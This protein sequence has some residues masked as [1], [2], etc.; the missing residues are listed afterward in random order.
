MPILNVK[1]SQ[2]PAL[3]PAVIGKVAATLS[4]LTHAI[5]GKD[6]ALTA[7]AIDLV[8]ASQWF[9]G[10]TSLADAQQS[11][12]WLDIVVTESTN[13]KDEKAAYVR[14]VFAAMGDLLGPVAAESYVLVRE[15]KADAYGYGGRTQEARYVEAKM[16]V[17]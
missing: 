11:S 2:S 12:F 6:P 3:T 16:K 14:A 17:A 13:T 5:L 10:G 1:L 4:R 8:P 7:V 15:V 9:V